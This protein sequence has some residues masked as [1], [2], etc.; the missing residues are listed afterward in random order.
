MCGL[1]LYECERVGKVG[2]WRC[3]L[4]AEVWPCERGGVALL[5][6]IKCEN[7]GCLARKKRCT[8]VEESGYSF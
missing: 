5:M 8:K 2:C 7:V 1:L 3:R 6:E 4:K